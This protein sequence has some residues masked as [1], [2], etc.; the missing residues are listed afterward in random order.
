[1]LGQCCL[2]ASACFFFIELSLQ[3][4]FYSFDILC[5]KVNVLL[6]RCYNCKKKKKLLQSSDFS[7]VTLIKAPIMSIDFIESL[8]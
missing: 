1:M 2:L 5:L 7:L 6:L 3:C 8:V 4:K